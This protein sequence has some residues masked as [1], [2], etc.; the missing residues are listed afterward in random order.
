MF[1]FVQ[2]DWVFPEINVRKV[3]GLTP[4]PQVAHALAGGRCA[5]AFFF[6]LFLF[7]LKGHYRRLTQELCRGNTALHFCA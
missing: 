2:S 5:L 1:C 6:C 4:W 3:V 7:L